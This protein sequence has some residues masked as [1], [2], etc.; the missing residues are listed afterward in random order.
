MAN[1]LQMHCVMGARNG[2]SGSWSGTTTVRLGGG[3]RLGAGGGEMPGRPLPDMGDADA[4]AHTCQ[5][6]GSDPW[7]RQLGSEVPGGFGGY[8]LDSGVPTAYLTDLTQADAAALA[9]AHAT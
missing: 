5:V 9:L 8:F 1:V 7:M 6:E 4:G 3:A 2:E